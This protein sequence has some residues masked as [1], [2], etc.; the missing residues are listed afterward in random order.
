MKYLFLAIFLIINFGLFSQFSDNFT[1]GDLTLNPQWIGNV[2]SFIVNSNSELQLN[3]NVTGSSYL[4]TTN[5]SIN[6]TQWQF[7][8]KINFAP[9]ANNNVSIFLTSNNSDLTVPLNGYFIRIGENLSDDGIDLFRKDGTTETLIINGAP[10]TATNGGT[11]TIKVLRDNSGNWQLFSDITGGTNFLPEGSTTDATY[12]STNNFGLLCKYTSSNISNFYFDDFYVGPIIYDTTAPKLQNL[13]ITSQNQLQLTFSESLENVSANNLTNYTVN[14]GIGNP[15]T[16]SLNQ[17]IVD[18]SF[19]QNFTI[20]Q[21]NTLNLSNLSDLEGNILNTFDTTF[22]YFIINENDIVINEIMAD[23][24]PQI[25]L[26]AYEFIEIY[27]TTPY[28]LN[29]TG[30]KIQ[31]GGTVKDLTNFTLTPNGFALIC[32]DNVQT[33][34]STYGNITTVTSL[35]L[36]NAGETII[37]LNEN[38]DTINTVS[39]TDQWYNDITK[40]DGGWTLEKIDPLNNCSGSLNWTASINAIGGTPNNTNS[41]FANNT[42]IIKPIVTNSILGS[43]NSININFSEEIDN[44]SIINTSNYSLST[45][46][47]LNISQTNNNNIEITLSTNLTNG[48][49]ISLNIN[50]LTDYC[51][52]IINDTTLNFTYYKAQQFDVVINEIMADATP[53]VYLPEAEYIELFNRTNY[54]I[55]MHNWTLKYGNY[56]TTIPDINIK[57][58]SFVIICNEASTALFSNYTNV[59]GVPSINLSATGMSLVLQDEASKPIH[60]VNYDITW[61]KNTNKDDGGWSLEQIDPNNPCG[62]YDNWETST[63]NNGGTPTKINSVFNVNIDNTSPELVSAYISDTNKIIIQLSESVLI[64]SILPNIF[65]VN[66]NIGVAINVNSQSSDNSIIQLVFNNNFLENTTYTLSLLAT[67]TD[68]IG[69]V[70]NE[71]KTIKFGYPIRPAKNDIIIN[72]ILFNPIDDGVDYV[73]IYNLSPNIIDL[74]E[75]K[76]ATKTD[77]VLDNLKIVSTTPILIFPQEYFVISTSSR[78]VKLQYTTKTKYNFVDIETLPTYS[79]DSGTIVITDKADIILDE[80]EYSENMQFPTLVSFEGVSLE[81]INPKTSTYLTSNWHS[82]AESV[83][84]GTPGYQNSQYNPESNGIGS[85]SLEKDVFSPDNDGFDDILIVNYNLEK[86]GYTGNIYIFDANGRLIKQLLKNELLAI[87]GS[88]NWDGIDDYNQKV[89]I[90]VYILVFEVFDLEGTLKKT[91]LPFVVA[92]KI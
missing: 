49:N 29:L 2:D 81:R 64:D 12:T 80:L 38:N 33:D 71:E 61:Y 26:P 78:I 7:K 70:I 60:T 46:N 14:N 73:E 87:S 20:G 13:E 84:Y 63:S 62:D 83:G 9:S 90:G 31:I 54:N 82:A 11:F 72:E 53:S 77:G 56:S 45:N 55:S 68:C 48:D 57:P 44:Y 42:D 32:D 22:T 39:Y 89:K 41:V 75:L 35:S 58:D 69:N 3:A 1:D 79:N 85:F 37:L 86:S 27:N 28:N 52:N 92:G 65:S 23:P 43:V 24:S 34:F 18:L 91:K 4:S 51:G 19:T 67:F 74:S 88:F 10:A 8:V 15:A 66:N 17:N 40:A 25:G 30:W 50:N 5:T 36:L 21:L 16:I 47:I 59:Y 76:I 6:N